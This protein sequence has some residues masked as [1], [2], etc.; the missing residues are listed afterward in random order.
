MP[1]GVSTSVRLVAS[2]K[3]PLVEASSHHELFVDLPR[4][5]PFR[6]A[7]PEAGVYTVWALARGLFGSAPIEVELTE[8]EP[9]EEI[10][11]EIPA[12]ASISGV[13]LD[14]SGAAV[15]RAQVVAFVDEHRFGSVDE[16]G[17]RSDRRWGVASAVTSEDGAFRLEPLSPLA[18]GYEL[19]ITPTRE[20]SD[21][22]PMSWEISNVRPGTRHLVVVRPSRVPSIASA[23]IFPIATG[24]EIIEIDTPLELLHVGS[25]GSIFTRRRVHVSMEPNRGGA[26]IEHLRSG[27]LYRVAVL[28]TEL[29][30][31]A[32]SEPFQATPGEVRAS[33][34]LPSRASLTIERA[35]SN[36]CNH[37]NHV[38]VLEARSG[39]GG[40]R[41][42]ARREAVH[43]WPVELRI[44]SGTYT[45]VVLCKTC[46]TTNRGAVELGATGS[47]VVIH[48]SKRD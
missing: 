13:V 27:A 44:P 4:Q 38:L 36:Q 34:P 32:Y 42:V 31:P 9:V 17:E 41:V 6:L 22:L 3:R 30:G 29:G 43:Q 19:D 16:V 39:V 7:L 12:P 5:G 15:S 2:P 24:G 11:I 40:E 1:R 47:R 33:I 28:D 45:V 20:E 35:G 18:R 37:P 21:D 25:R 26:R 10:N 46:E 48:S 14:E 23:R 8:V